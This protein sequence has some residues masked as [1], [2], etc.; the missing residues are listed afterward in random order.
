MIDTP[1]DPP[2]DDTGNGGEGEVFAKS[3]VA[4]I[5]DFAEQERLRSAAQRE[6]ALRSFEVAEKAEQ[7]QHELSLRQVE[8][9]NERDRRRHRLA[10]YVIILLAGVPLALLTLVVVM[11][12]FGNER[13]SQIALNLLGIVGTALGGA[14]V[15]FLVAFAINRLVSR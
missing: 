15:V 10:V 13:Q 9:E 2:S 8:A 7:L 12:F 11:A 1:H 4:A 5:T 6:V 3:L 14:G